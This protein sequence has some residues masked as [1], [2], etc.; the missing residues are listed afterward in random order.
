M[1]FGWWQLRFLFL[2]FLFIRKVFIIFIVYLIFF[3]IVI[4]LVAFQLNRRL[5]VVQIE[6]GTFLRMV[7]PFWGALLRKSCCCCWPVS[8]R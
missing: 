2:F 8:G 1:P 7:T 5:I 4:I 6:F 3:F